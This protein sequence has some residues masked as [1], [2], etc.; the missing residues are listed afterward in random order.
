MLARPHRKKSKR[1]KMD[2]YR[3]PKCNKLV[4][5]YMRRCKTCHQLL[6]RD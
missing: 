5:I 6:K 3:C 4:R 2:R 1:D